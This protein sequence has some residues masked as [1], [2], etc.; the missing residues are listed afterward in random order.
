MWGERF[1]RTRDRLLDC[2]CRIESLAAD[3]DL[4]ARPVPEEALAELLRPQRVVL[5]GEVNAGK[6][7]IIN[8]MVGEE[9]A[10]VSPLP[11]TKGT[12][13]YTPVSSEV[14]AGWTVCRRALFGAVEWIDTP[15]LNGPAREELFSQ[16]DRFSEGDLILIV[17]PSENTW[18]AATW[19][20]VS[21]LSDETLERTTL[22]IQRS[23]RKSSEDIRVIRGH[24]RELCTKK[25]GRELPILAVAANPPKEEPYLFE[26]K[27]HFEDRFCHSMMRRHLMDRGF[28]E[29]LR[30]L[31]E[32]E[33]GLDRQGRQ[34]ADDGWFLSGLEE[35]SA[36]LCDLLIKHSDKI[37]AGERAVYLEEI[38]RLMDR[39]SRRL[40]VL[41][42][43]RSLLFGD[44]L[45]SVMEVRFAERLKANV[46]AFSK[47]DFE[48]IAGECEGHWAEVRPRV[49]E[50]MNIEPNR[51]STVTEFRE[52]IEERFSAH[53]D[54]SLPGVVSSLRI[55]SSL[56]GPIRSR[57]DRL[58]A[59]LVFLLCSTIAMGLCGAFGIHPATE[60]LAALVALLTVGWVMAVW[61]SRRRVVRQVGERLSDGVGRFHE[62]LAERHAEAI[63]E[64]FEMYGRGLIGVRRRLADRQAKLAPRSEVWNLLHL[65]LRAV[66]QDGG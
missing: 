53:V 1:Y 10:P 58:K 22:V 2:R 21:E 28:H 6:S 19:D 44:A 9:I 41:G 46:E 16:V 63:R 15:G 8:A 4:P 18:T 42:T 30:R 48:R 36:E 66:E 29:A 3:V 65:E 38:S 47:R 17:F 52:T 56:D 60:I 61:V 37:L 32:I 39:V 5:I 40:G 57:G 7:S 23:D 25:V 62:Q 13:L 12:I 45:G 27:K 35:E 55:R 51:S 20:F 64:V 26:L 49:M 59:W 14:P 11:T 31:R 24:M 33:E 34:M 54:R 50:R 43:L